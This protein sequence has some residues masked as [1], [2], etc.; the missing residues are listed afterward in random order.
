MTSQLPVQLASVLVALFLAMPAWAQSWD[1]GFGIGTADI[2]VDA[3]PLAE[4][5]ERSGHFATLRVR[6]TNK[7]AAT[8]AVIDI[9]SL[10]VEGGASIYRRTVDLP[11][12][13][14]KDVLM[15]YRGGLGGEVEEVTVRAGR[16]TFSEEFKRQPIG[17]DDVAIAVI[18]EDPVGTTGIS[19]AGSIVPMT[20][21]GGLVS[22]PRDVRVGLIPRAS[23]PDRSIGYDAF[24]WVIWPQADPSSLSPES[25]DA[26]EN[27][28][29]GGGHL[30]LTVS[31]TWQQVMQSQLGDMLPVTLTGT[32]DVSSF[33]GLTDAVGLPAVEGIPAPVAEGRLRPEGFEFAKVE[34]ST[35]WAARPY[36]LG[37]VHV[38]LANPSVSPLK[39]S[40][41]RDVLWR[42]LLWMSTDDFMEQ[43][44][45]GRGPDTLLLK[46]LGE[47]A[48]LARNM[49]LLRPSASSVEHV[50]NEWEQ[51]DEQFLSDLKAILADIPGVAPLPMPWLLAFSILYLI[52]IG[53]FDY[54]VLRAFRR[55]PMTW[56]TFPIYIAVF[57]GVALA[58]TSFF[59]GGQSILSELEVIDILPDAGVWRGQSYAGLFSASKADVVVSSPVRD[60]AVTLLAGGGYVRDP[61]HQTTGAGSELGYRADTWTLG[62]VRSHW[63]EKRKETL[64]LRRADSGRWFVKN[65]LGVPLTDIGYLERG[66]AVELGRLEPGAELELPTER[67]I[68]ELPKYRWQ[69]YGAVYE[70]RIAETILWMSDLPS[71]FP[72]YIDPHYP[73]LVGRI[74][75]PSSF[76]IDG[77]RPSIDRA[78]LV[79]LR[80]DPIVRERDASRGM[81]GPLS[82]RRARA[83]IRGIDF[84]NP[85]EI[86]VT[87]P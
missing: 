43:A 35:V 75:R 70:D 56:V 78:T 26:L 51:P 80:L 64:S 39:G 19:T 25:L 69:S 17:Q 15:Y 73:M 24:N 29:A 87:T 79:R 48:I 84:E 40:V 45:L 58:G 34:G 41:S 2:E 59:K 66:K 9:D 86:E 12:G 5:I 28:V 21:P 62:Y 18:G 6:L 67:P 65:E 63:M 47:G 37:T 20:R 60:S 11:E 8:T 71:E 54:F 14:K 85:T 32:R 22:E 30:F 33:K 7:G 68:Q 49:H 31:D 46:R 55:Q 23:L 82:P 16:S 13:G 57:S 38:L 36:G 4:G 1:L 3:R 52:V 83:A 76:A 53:P 42:E 27:W 74:E 44:G 72:G 10:D 77:L 61:A 81:G 50:D